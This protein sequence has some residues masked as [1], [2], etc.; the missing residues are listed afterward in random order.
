MEEEKIKNIIKNYIENNFLVTFGEDFLN[1][2][3]LFKN[4]TIDSFGY[5]E[6]VKFLENEFKINIEDEDLTSG[7][8]NSLKNITD[9][10]L[11]KIK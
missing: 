9:Y 2:D 8:L 10:I 7:A 1:D 4:G 6:L 11:N 3:N 5:I